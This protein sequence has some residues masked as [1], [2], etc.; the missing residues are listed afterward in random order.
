MIFVWLLL[1]WWNLHKFIK[2][3]NDITFRPFPI[4]IF[5]CINWA[6]YTQIN[7]TTHSWCLSWKP[8][9]ITI[10]MIKLVFSMQLCDLE[11]TSSIFLHDLG[12]SFCWTSTISCITTGSIRIIVCIQGTIMVYLLFSPIH[13]RLKASHSWQFNKVI[14]KWFQMPYIS[15]INHVVRILNWL[16]VPNSIYID[17][18]FIRVRRSFRIHHFLFINLEQF[19]R[20]WLYF[21]HLINSILEIKGGLKSILGLCVR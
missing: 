11:H 8:I 12:V 3:F 5:L 18:S 21:M 6:F 14:S 10:W 13:L 15:D 19:S 4:S 7:L 17:H 9:D 1:N 20:I 16:K 2:P